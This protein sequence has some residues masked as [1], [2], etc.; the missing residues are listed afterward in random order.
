MQGFRSIAAAVII[1]TAILLLGLGS[2]PARSQQDKKPIR[3]ASA[4]GIHFV[5]LW[6]LGPFAEKHGLRT[7]MVAAMTNDRSIFSSVN[8]IRDNSCIDE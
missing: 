8:G 5:A 3:I 1:P 2:Y 6:G 4:R 7:E